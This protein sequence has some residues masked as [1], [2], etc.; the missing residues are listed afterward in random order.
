MKD[1]IPLFVDLV[2]QGGGAKDEDQTVSVVYI[3]PKAAEPTQDATKDFTPKV[4]TPTVR[5][6][7]KPVRT[8]VGGPTRPTRAELFSPA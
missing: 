8:E 7:R 2:L 6:P 5:E 3:E 4:E 1:L